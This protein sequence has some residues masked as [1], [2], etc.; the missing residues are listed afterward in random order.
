MS[1]SVRRYGEA[2]AEKFRRK[3]SLTQKGQCH[4]KHYD[5]ARAY[6]I[7]G[8]LIIGCKVQGACSSASK[9]NFYET[10]RFMKLIDSFILNL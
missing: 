5:F 7:P 3:N 2:S 9:T 1:G 4:K 8:S 6:I 10:G